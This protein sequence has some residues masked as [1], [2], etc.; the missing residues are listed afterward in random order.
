M[1]ETEAAARTP[2][3]RVRRRTPSDLAGKNRCRS[4]R[5]AQVGGERVGGTGVKSREKRRSL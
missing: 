5:G 3:A 2:A 1:N 4:R